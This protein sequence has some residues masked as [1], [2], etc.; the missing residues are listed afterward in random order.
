[1]AMEIFLCV[2]LVG[3]GWHIRRFVSE[4]DTRKAIATA[5]FALALGSFLIFYVVPREC[6]KP[7][8][9]ISSFI[10]M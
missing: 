4:R 2:G 6:E 10:Y 1:M 7:V 8:V 3:C 5:V 9:T